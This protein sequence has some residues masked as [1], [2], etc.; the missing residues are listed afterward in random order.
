[1]TTPTLNI[2]L[3]PG[4]N[5]SFEIEFKDIFPRPYV[6]E[7][8]SVKV[9][10]FG[11]PVLNK[12]ISKEE[13]ALN[14]IKH[15]GLK[16]DFI[17]S[18][19]GEFLI[20]YSDTSNEKFQIANDRFTSIPLYYYFDKGT[21]KASIKYIEIAKQLKKDK[22]W[23]IDNKFFFEFLWF[24]RL[25][26]QNT[27]DM[28]SKFLKSAR[29][30]TLYSKELKIDSYWEPSF[31]KSNDLSLD[32][33][34][35][36]LVKSIGN[37]ISEKTSDIK[38]PS[39]IGLFLSG[40]MDTRTLLGAF[41]SSN[42][43]K[44]AC[45]TI[46]YSKK[47]E[48]RV[49][50]KVANIVGSECK[51]IK[52]NGDY[53][54]QYLKDKADLAGGMYNQFTNIFMGQSEK[55]SPYSRF[56]FHGHGFDYMFQGMYLPAKYV[57]LFGKNT[58]FKKISKLN[59]VDDLAKYYV[60]NIGYRFN[61]FSI[62]DFVIPTYRDEMLNSLYGSVKEILREGEKFCNDNFD[63][64]EYLMIH[65]ISRHY[66]QMDIAGIGTNG[67]QRKIAN[68]NNILDLYLRMPLEYRKDAK[69]MR[70]ALKIINPS[71]SKM[72]SSNT[73]YCI[74]ASPLKLTSHFI[75]YKILRV[76]TGNQKFR[77]PGFKERTWPNSGEQIKDLSILHNLA[78][79]AINS[80][81]LHKQMP[82]LDWKKIKLYS[83]E[84]IEKKS[85]G[86]GNF[87]MHLMSIHSLLK[88]I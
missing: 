81:I 47:G 5:N 45:F 21:I 19:N 24:R 22:L 13:V 8:K 26:G 71:L 77:H 76:I 12:K 44:P 20:I 48:Y 15:D 3:S 54:S 31:L 68:D 14:I 67:E 4:A 83:P 63:L 32:Y 73:G 57:T 18:L 39:E 35:N 82:Y 49:A 46:G 10:I 16:K 33:Y 69:V 41:S 62:S 38:D 37:S 28:K 34:A 53:Y 36:E 25:H 66:S 11:S 80:E 85:E 84:W 78:N 74:D 1:M 64:W 87:L 40:G 30:L 42:N 72:E 88:G 79:E 51:F 75:F 23:Q 43:I 59:N 61:Q 29:I 56:L 52:L 86:G 60:H 2:Y 6:E 17:K 55:I 70:A 65:T 58:H 50:K 9:V 27:Y 7:K